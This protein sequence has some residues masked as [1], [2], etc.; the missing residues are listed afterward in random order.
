MYKS[1]GDPYG[2]IKDAAVQHLTIDGRFKNKKA[3]ISSILNEMLIKHDIENGKITL[4][5]WNKIC[6]K[7]DVIFGIKYRVDEEL[8]EDIF[9]FMTVHPDGSFHFKVNDPSDIFDFNIFTKC[10]IIFSG[11]EDICGIVVD[12]NEQINVIKKTDWMTIPEIEKIWDEF[13]QDRVH[14][15]R[16]ASGREEFLEGCLDI[17][18]FEKDGGCYYFVGT[19][20]L[21][22]QAKIAHAVNIRKIEPYDGAPLFFE[23]LLPLMNTTFVHNQ[24]LTVVPF[25]FKYLRE[26]A[27]I[28]AKEVLQKI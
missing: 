11:S 3:Q 4:Y 2:T 10:Q 20:G 1:G 16:S 7:K 14:E 12:E 19:I 25:P 24:R 26:W 22:M 8:R 13:K 18:M 5:D 23:P 9:C 28:K 6:L 27:K 21:G 15:F 17:K